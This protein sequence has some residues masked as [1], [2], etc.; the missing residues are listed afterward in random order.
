MSAD[1]AIEVKGLTKRFRR[2]LLKRDYTTW[3][4]LLLKPFTAAKQADLLT[5]LDGVDLSL[6]TGRTLAII[7]ENGS[8]KSTFLKIL[9][10][11]Y[12][13]DEGLVKVQG[14]VSSLIELGAGFHPE[15]SGRENVFLNGTILGLSKKEIGERY[16][17]IVDY[18]GLGEFMEAPVRTYSSGMYVRLGFAVAVNVDPDVL[19]VDEVL[20]VGD[21]AFSHKC[22]DKLNEFKRAGKTICLVSHDL[23]AV[24]KFADEVIWLDGGVIAAQG[25]PARVI[26]QYRQVVAQREDESGRRAAAARSGLECDERWGYGEVEITAVRLLDESGEPHSVFTSGEPITIEMDYLIHQQVEGL[27][28]GVAIHNTAGVLCYGS[29]THLDTAQLG[30]APPAGTVRFMAQR[31][32]LVQGTYMLDVAA[33][34]P[35]GRDY[36]YLTQVATFAVRGGP[37][38]DAGVYRPPHHWSLSPREESP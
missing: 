23:Q 25:D 28:F 29:N 27:A 13:A 21:E 1:L 26:D 6:P 10:G 24:K 38:G 7:G 34:S 22:E 18:S 33:N 3:K 31:L 16:Q 5:V 17:Q 4:S 30:P 15:F 20:A 36:D 19:L 2:E 12:K 32:D 9:A 37:E 35:E 11:I 8:G 14:R